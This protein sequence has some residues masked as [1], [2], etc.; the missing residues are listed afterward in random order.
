[1][2]ANNI[3]DDAFSHTSSSQREN[4]GAIFTSQKLDKL[5]KLFDAINKSTINDS[6]YELSKATASDEHGN[7]TRNPDTVTNTSNRI[8]DEKNIEFP[9]YRRSPFPSPA[10]E[11]NCKSATGAD[12]AC[13]EENLRGCDARKHV[14]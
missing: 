10:G 8:M 13:G 5:D 12:E 2:E 14:D 3:T 7:R 1:M 4:P 11:P 6:I 9:N